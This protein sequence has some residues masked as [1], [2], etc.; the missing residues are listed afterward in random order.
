M[1]AEGA[2]FAEC[3]FQVADWGTFYFTT[4]G[5]NGIHKG[6]QRFSIYYD[7]LRTPSWLKIVAYLSAK[8]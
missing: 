2:D 4:K 6:P 1:L 5:H 3:L 7:I 8:S